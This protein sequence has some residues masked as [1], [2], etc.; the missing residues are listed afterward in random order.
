MADAKTGYGTTFKRSDTGLSGG[1]MT[2][3][4]KVRSLTPAKLSRGTKD[5]THLESPGGYREFITD[6]RDGGEFSVE[7]YLG[8]TDA[9][10]DELLVDFADDD[11]GYYEMEMSNGAVWG[12]AAFITNLEPPT[13]NVDGEL[14]VSATFKVTGQP[15]W[16]AGT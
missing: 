14:I 1:V 15:S 13:I 4:A 10:Y 11:P 2:A 5:V 6:L 8:A 16:T 12:Y 3:I 9:A 7:L